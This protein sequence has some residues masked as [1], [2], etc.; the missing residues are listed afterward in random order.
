MNNNAQSGQRSTISLEKPRSASAQPQFT[1]Y[2]RSTSAQPQYTEYKPGQ[3]NYNYT[4]KNSNQQSQT[5]SLPN[6]NNYQQSQARSLPNQNNNQQISPYNSENNN[7]YQNYQDSFDNR[8]EFTSSSFMERFTRNGSES[9]VVGYLL[10][11]LG[12]LIGAIPGAL[13]IIFLGTLGYVA[14]ASGAVLFFGVFYLYRMLSGSVNN[15]DKI[16][17]TIVIGTC[18]IGVFLSVKA[19]YSLQIASALGCSFG[20]VFSNLSEILSMADC[21]F[22]FIISLLIT[23]IAAFVGGVKI[24]Q[25]SVK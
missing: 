12:A 13:L 21:T 5:R 1:E 10:G 20:E 7:P 3:S 24:L 11:T 8:L 14:Y 22:K 25:T 4:P 17:W 15:F 19:S 9:P 6:Q 18:V 16:D 2:K 23:Y